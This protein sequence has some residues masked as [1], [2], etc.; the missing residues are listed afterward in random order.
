MSRRRKPQHRRPTSAVLALRCPDCDSKLSWPDPD[1][2][3]LGHDPTCPTWRA[4]LV[5]QAWPPGKEVLM[6]A[7]AV[8]PGGDPPL[9]S[10]YEK[11]LPTIGD[12]KR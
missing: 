7:R 5:V 9:L 3:F 6:L 1:V 2:I 11:D 8:G 10:E 12:L 4:R